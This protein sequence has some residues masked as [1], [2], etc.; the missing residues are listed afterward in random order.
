MS[1][2]VDLDTLVAYWLAE[3]DESATEAIDEHLFACDACGA[4]L[5]ELIALEQGVREAFAA[6]RVGAFVAPAFV[7]GLLR[8]GS[9]VRE[10]RVPAGGS[11]DCGV[12]PEDEVLVSRYQA[13]L[14]GVQRLD[15]VIRTSLDA[16][17][18]R[19]EDIPFDPAA[20]EVVWLARLAWVR[21]LPAHRF[22]V[23]LLEGDKV[24]A[25]YTMNHRP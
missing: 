2:H 7:E 22:H 25:E 12:G 14:A 5:D 24:I 18:R 17:E 8:R 10:Y 6:G 15:A 21:T 9:R 23:R 20:G 4:Q 19:L 13:P 1:A 3:T 16:S 11:I